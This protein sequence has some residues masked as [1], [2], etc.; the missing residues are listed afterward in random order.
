[1]D[2][3]ILIINNLDEGIGGGEGEREV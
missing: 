2:H 1:M 3:K